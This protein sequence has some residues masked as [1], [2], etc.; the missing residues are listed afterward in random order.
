M[1]KGAPDDGMDLL[2]QAMRKAHA[3]TFGNAAER[4]SG[5][6][7]PTDSDTTKKDQRPTESR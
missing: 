4:A 7:K 6:A 2:A 1:S 3:E 5:D